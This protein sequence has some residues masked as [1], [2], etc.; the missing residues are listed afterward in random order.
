MQTAQD[1]LLRQRSVAS[2]PS[3]FETVLHQGNQE[4][5]AFWSRTHRFAYGDNELPGQP[6]LAA[7]ARAWAMWGAEVVCDDV[8]N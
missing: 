4:Q 7:G 1:L 2:I 3:K 5:N 6:S 8:R